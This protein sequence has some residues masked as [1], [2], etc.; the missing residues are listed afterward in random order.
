MSK[1]LITSWLGI[2]WR[3]IAATSMFAG[4]LA[5]HFLDR[6]TTSS[7]AVGVDRPTT[8]APRAAPTSAPRLVLA[9]DCGGSKSTISGDDASGA[10][11]VGA[12]AVLHGDVGV[13]V[14][15]FVSESL[16]HCE[17]SDGRYTVIARPEKIE[18]VGPRPG[19][20]IK[21]AC[22]R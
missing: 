9:V 21:Y 22:T 19:E 20:T 13:C 6:S 8:R 3:A 18:V 11:T 5:L 7:Q 10:F 2:N 4:L 14:V 12:D 16:P 15:T 1:F 17:I